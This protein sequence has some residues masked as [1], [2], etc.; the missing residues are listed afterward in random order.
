M[1]SRKIA[2]IPAY[3]PEAGLLELVRKIR[4]KGLEVVVVDDGSSR[5]KQGLFRK[6][7]EEAT[8]LRHDK[9]RGKGRAL[10]TGFNYIQNSVSSDYVIVTVDADGQH[11]P[12]DVKKVCEAGMENPGQLILGSRKMKGDIPLRSRFGNTVTRI[13][14]RLATGMKVYDTQTGLRAF[15]RKTAHRFAQV[16]GERYEYEM[17]VLLQCAREK[18]PV[19]EVEIE[20]VYIDE[21]RTS[22]FDTIKDSVRIYKEILKFSAV[23]FGS[24]LIDYGI[25]SGMLCLTAGMLPDSARIISNVTARIVSAGVNYTA[26]RNI[27]FQSNEKVVQSS[28]KYLLLVVLILV[29][30]TALLEIFVRRLGM[31]QYVGKICAELILFIVSWFVQSHFIFQR[32]ED[33]HGTVFKKA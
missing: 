17:N 19:R 29:A 18:I 27:V 13:V 22:H 12:D 1:N 25:Y 15:D 20:T 26:N 24:F 14:Y 23:S 11:K 7:E 21:N 31:N 5:E 8:V 28:G 10:K 4:E 3:Q 9:N 32:R 33:A 16:E 6:I 2:L 30:N